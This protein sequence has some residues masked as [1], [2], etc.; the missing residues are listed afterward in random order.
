MIEED[1]EKM[2]SDGNRRKV[3]EGVNAET[4]RENLIP[5]LLIACS[6]F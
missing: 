2:E 3:K 4:G 6:F 1:G 5:C